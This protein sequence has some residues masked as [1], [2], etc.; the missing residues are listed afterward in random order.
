MKIGERNG[1]MR[2]L[3][4]RALIVCAATVTP[5]LAPGAQAAALLPPTGEYA[6][7]ENAPVGDEL[8]VSVKA[9]EHEAS[10]NSL[11]AQL[12]LAQLYTDGK[13][14]AKDTFKACRLYSE[15]ASGHS[16]MDPKHP[17]AKNVGEAYR[18]WAKCYVKGLPQPGWTRN[19][20]AAAELYFHAGVV[21]GDV[22]ALYELALLYLAGQGVSQ[23][24]KLGIAHLYTTSR[25]RYP[26]ALARL[27][28]L[29]W[30]GRVMKRLP[31]A[32]LALLILAKDGCEPDD[33]A[34]ITSL[35]DDAMI[36]ATHD[37]EAEAVRVAAEWRSTYGTVPRQA[38]KPSEPAET[39]T[40]TAPVAS[41]GN[42]PASGEQQRSHFSNQPT[43]GL[44]VPGE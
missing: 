5:L 6:L 3:I 22:P 39:A 13:F 21:F 38:A 25:K 24:T 41:D 12:S 17:L 28:N 37:E 33:R 19:M 43:R 30:E 9:L 15:A 11:R 35:Y 44:S 32:G 36:T 2:R 27:G 18:N 14:V 34:W 16:K 20:N 31:A 23:N 7:A 29:M 10:Q 8:A 4:L 40:V 42:A 26:P 1:R